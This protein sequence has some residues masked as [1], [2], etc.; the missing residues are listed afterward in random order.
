MASCHLIKT[1]V[2]S[3]QKNSHKRTYVKDI[4]PNHSLNAAFHMLATEKQKYFLCNHNTKGFD[5]Y[6]VLVVTALEKEAQRC[7]A[8]DDPVVS[9][10][11]CK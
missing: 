11:A 2:T 4:G 9:D 1:A 10:K 5:E 3:D 7:A 8:V 6:C